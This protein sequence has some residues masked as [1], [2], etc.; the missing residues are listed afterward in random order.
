MAAVPNNNRSIFSH[1][2][3]LQA[4]IPLILWDCVTNVYKP[5]IFFIN[6][7]KLNMQPIEKKMLFVK[8]FLHS[9]KMKRIILLT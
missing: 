9:A 7:N 2:L 5:L 8:W 6:C 1:L 3:E 4:I